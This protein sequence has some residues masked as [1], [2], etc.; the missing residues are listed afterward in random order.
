MRARTEETMGNGG[1][2]GLDER[3]QALEAEVAAMRPVVCAAIALRDRLAD[4]DRCDEEEEDLMRV[5]R[6]YETKTTR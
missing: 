4:D 1:V 2:V 5:V 3:I 6:D